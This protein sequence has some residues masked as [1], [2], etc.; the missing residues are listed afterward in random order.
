MN[1]NIMWGERSHS[2]RAMYFIISLNE[3]SRIGRFVDT[4]N[5]LGDCLEGQGNWR[6]RTKGCVF[7]FCLFVFLC[8][9]REDNLNVLKFIAV[10]DAQFWEYNKMMNCMVC[11]LYL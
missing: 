8:V 7:L 9:W 4:E 10:M 2:Q 3:M 5:R 6:V 11:W 1:K